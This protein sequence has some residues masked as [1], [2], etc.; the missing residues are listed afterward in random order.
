[1]T[2]QYF[3]G[4]YLEAHTL[5][6]A[7]GVRKAQRDYFIM[8]PN[9]LEDLGT[10]IGLQCRDS[11]LAHDLEHALG[12]AFT[13]SRHHGRIIRKRFAV[14]LAIPTCLPKRLQGEIGIDR[15]NT[16]TDQQAM[17]VHFAGFSG[18]DHKRDAG[19]LG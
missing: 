9:R 3:L 1:M 4:Q 5:K 17:V 18:F 19:A 16:K 2:S 6:T 12:N 14:E 15:I 13:I 7:G 8:K 11:H 10:F